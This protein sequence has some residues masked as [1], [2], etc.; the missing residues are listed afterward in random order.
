MWLQ[1]NDEKGPYTLPGSVL[2]NC[3]RGTLPVAAFSTAVD[4]KGSP[5]QVAKLYLETADFID[6]VS[7]R[8]RDLNL[9]KG[10]KSKELPYE[11][12][13]I[14]ASIFSRDNPDFEVRI[15]RNGDLV[16]DAALV[17]KAK[18]EAIK[19]VPRGDPPSWSGLT[20]SDNA[21]S[22]SKTGDKRKR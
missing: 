17:A 4:T 8:N 11:N 21:S 5:K 18:A 7:C 2:K 3:K 12:G 20:S 9:W 6:E 19:C 13:S 14:I 16:Y 1:Y 15:T 10:Q 22:G